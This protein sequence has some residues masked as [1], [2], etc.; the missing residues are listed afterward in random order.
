MYINVT[1]SKPHTIT[2]SIVHKLI[3]KNYHKESLITFRYRIFH[4]FYYGNISIWNTNL[5]GQPNEPKHNPNHFTHFN[6]APNNL[7][8]P[9]RHDN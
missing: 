6:L 8:T 2:Q 9:V 1:T 4:S 3:P 5:Q 7:I